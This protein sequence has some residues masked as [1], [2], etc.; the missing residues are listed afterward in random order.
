MKPGAVC[1]LTEFFDMFLD[2]G[3]STLLVVGF[4]VDKVAPGVD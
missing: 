2:H 3:S 4:H 1:W